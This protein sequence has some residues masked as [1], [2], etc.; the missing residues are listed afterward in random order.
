[1]EYPDAGKYEPA[2]AIVVLAL[3][4]FALH[5]AAVLHGV[6]GLCGSVVKGAER[7]VPRHFKIAVIHLEV[8]VMHLVVERAQR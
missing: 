7:F 2:P 6:M 8:T 4:V 5:L 3:S 1:M